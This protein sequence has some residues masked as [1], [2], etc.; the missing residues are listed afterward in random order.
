VWWQT[1]GENACNVPDGPINYV[2]AYL[3]HEEAVAMLALV[4]G[5]WILAGIITLE[6]HGAVEKL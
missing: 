2:G 4:K 3:D 6:L 5:D 1:A